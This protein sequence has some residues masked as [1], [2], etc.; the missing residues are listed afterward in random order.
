MNEIKCTLT[1]TEIFNRLM[2]ND[3]IVRQNGAIK[4]CFEEYYSPMD[5]EGNEADYQIEISD[6]LRKVIATHTKQKL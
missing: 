6:E 5:D 3:V 2:E 4:K 1:S